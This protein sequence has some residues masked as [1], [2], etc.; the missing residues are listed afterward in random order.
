M[1]ATGPTICEVN[2]AY[3][4]ERIPRVVAR[5]L[6]DGTL[7]SGALHDQYPFLPQSEI[8]VN[9]SVSASHDDVADQGA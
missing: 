9:M 1:A 3:G 6:E 2:V 4:Q 7:V 5:R 8:E